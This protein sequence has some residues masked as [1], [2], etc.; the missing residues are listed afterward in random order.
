[1][2]RGGKRLGAGRKKGTIHRKTAEIANKIAADDEIKPLEVM[3]AAMRMAW[4]AGDIDTAVERAEKA[5]PYIH[6]RLAAVDHTSNGETI[7]NVYSGVPRADDVDTDQPTQ[8]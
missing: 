2:A 8:H 5:A 3:I 4:K 6:A 1:M 7:T